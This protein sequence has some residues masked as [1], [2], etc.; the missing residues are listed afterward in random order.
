MRRKHAE[1]GTS[2]LTQV[3]A[4]NLNVALRLSNCF[5]QPLFPAVDG[6]GVQ[7]WHLEEASFNTGSIVKKI[8]A[9]EKGRMNEIIKLLASRSVN[10]FVVSVHAC[11]LLLSQ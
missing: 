4:K 2:P 10:I 1:A 3:P 8:L 9:E 5:F 6:V 11:L 7:L